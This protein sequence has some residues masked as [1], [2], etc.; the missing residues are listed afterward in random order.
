[1]RITHNMMSNSIILNL[2][3]QSEQLF[4]VQT[5]IATQK[6]I[7]K[8]SDDPAGMGRVLEYRS[9]LEV[10]DQYQTNIQQGRS[11][12]ET[13]ELTLDLID[14]L[15]GLG[16][17]MALTYG[18]PDASP[19]AKQLAADEVD[20]LYDQIIQLANSKTGSDYLFSGHQTDTPPFGHVVEISGSVVGDIVF[21]L[22]AVAANVTIE[23]RDATDTVVRTIT[24]G[25]GGTDGINTVPWNGN[26]GGGAS[27][28]NGQYTFSITASDAAGDPVQ[29]YFTY[30]G[31]DGQQPVIIG[32]NVAVQLD[33]D[34]SNFFAPAGGVDV[35]EVLQD[36]V[37]GL[38]NPDGQAGSAQITATFDQFDQARVQLSNKRTEYG[39]KLYRLE[40]AEN[41]WANL[42]A[43]IEMAIGRIENADIT[44]AA[45]E[46]RNLE[47]AYESTIATAARMMQPGLL[48]FLK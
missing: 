9:K 38:R 11:L 8:P 2:Q 24:P 3:R 16:R 46:L 6:R 10:M 37:V 41:H 14:E 17:E 15:I 1:M 36:L 32:E 35:F 7:N 29:N 20:D 18:N 23:I 45:V 12:I 5:Q 33:M 42:S 22:S 21:G 40:H 39:P 48:N 30:N 43:N 19:E 34:G 4:N 44:R 28:P 13:N 31:D 27:L 25:A 26:D 47:L